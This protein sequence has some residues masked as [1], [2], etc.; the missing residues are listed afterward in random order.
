MQLKPHILF[1]SCCYK[2]NDSGNLLTRMQRKEPLYV[3]GQNLIATTATE[4]TMKSVQNFKVEQSQD[5]VISALRA[6]DPKERTSV[7]P[8]N[9]TII[10]S[11]QD[12]EDPKG[13]LMG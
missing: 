2:K 1:V 4:N 12:T 9:Y 13:P 3:T 7:S 6:I 10:S 8:V 11:G 5:A